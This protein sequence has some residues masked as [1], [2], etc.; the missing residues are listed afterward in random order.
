MIHMNFVNS[1][2]FLPENE[3]NFLDFVSEC[4]EAANI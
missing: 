1:L 2:E 3:V 4:P